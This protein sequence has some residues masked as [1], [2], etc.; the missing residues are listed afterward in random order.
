MAFG[1]ASPSTS[2]FVVED[3]LPPPPV[4]VLAPPPAVV[5]PAAPAPP[6]LPTVASGSSPDITLAKVPTNRRAT[7]LKGK[8]VRLAQLEE[9]EKMK[10]KGVVVYNPQTAEKMGNVDTI[11]SL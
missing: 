9:V 8:E 3:S 6:A 4:V 1:W 10:E 7:S 5:V 2:S 11:V